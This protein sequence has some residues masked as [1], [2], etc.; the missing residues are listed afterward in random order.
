MKFKQAMF[1]V[2]GFLAGLSVALTINSFGVELQVEGGGCKMGLAKD[3]MF[4][5]SDRQTNNDLSDGCYSVALAGRFNQ[6]LWGWRVGYHNLGFI[7]ARDNSATILDEEAFKPIAQICDTSTNKGCTM[8]M[9]GDGKTHGILFSITRTFP[10][11]YFDLVTEGGLFFFSTTFS[12]VGVRNADG[13]HMQVTETSGYGKPPA[14]VLGVGVRKGPI[15]A[16]YRKGWSLDH[17]EES[18]TDHSFQQLTVGLALEF[19]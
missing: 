17:R 9:Y 5:Q 7:R 14:P 13:L 8:T 1:A 12:A 18:L 4:Y 19:P 10:N 3:G 11:R 6:S 16:M 2:A 15:Y